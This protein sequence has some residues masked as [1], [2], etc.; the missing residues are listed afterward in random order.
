MLS[1]S[2]TFQPIWREKR[3]TA[4]GQIPSS[5]TGRVQHQLPYNFPPADLLHILDPKKICHAG[6]CEIWNKRMFCLLWI[7]QSIAIGHDPGGQR[8]SILFLRGQEFRTFRF[9]AS[10][11]PCHICRLPI[12]RP[13]Q[14]LGLVGTN[15]IGKSTALKVLAGKLKP[16]LGRFDVSFYSKWDQYRL[17]CTTWSYCLSVIQWQADCV[18][19]YSSKTARGPQQRGRNWAPPPPPPELGVWD[20]NTD[21]LLNRGDLISCTFAGCSRLARNSDLLAR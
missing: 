17:F 11:S 16:N 13:G 2:S 12:P 7:R 6:P 1:W 21:N 10:C 20:H 19:P 18:A 5:Y 14:V 3:P 4:M 15:G 8:H 9:N